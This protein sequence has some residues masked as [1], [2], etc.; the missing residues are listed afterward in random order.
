M[1]FLR[2][3]RY[4]N[5]LM[6]ALMQFVFRYGFLKYQG[7]ELALLDYQFCVLVFSTL[8]IA[9]GGYLINNIFDRQTDQY[10]KPDKIVIGKGIS[11]TRAYNYYFALNILG[12]AG[13]YYMS[14][15]IGKPGFTLIFILISA[16]LYMYASNL[17]QTLLLGNFIIALLL[18]CSL[19]IVGVYDLYPMIEPSTRY[20]LSL[21]FMALIYYAIFAFVVNFIR[22]IVKDLEDVDGDYNMGMNTLPIALG[23]NRAAKLVFWIGLIPTVY[24]TYYVYTHFFVN[25]FIVS[26]VYFLALVVAPLAYFNIKMWSAKG[27]RDFTHL[28]LIL[29]LVLFFGI[30]SVLVITFEGQANA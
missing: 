1:S 7:I 18:S 22:E 15:G 24:L 19:L 14:D 17:K 25:D 4:H 21:A 27:K 11:E 20:A 9:A 8:C 12:V 2:L 29:K 16:T 10:N 3:I 5:L 30:L 23:V 13:G 6:I 28:S 26:T